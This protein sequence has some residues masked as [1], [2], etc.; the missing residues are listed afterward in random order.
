MVPATASSLIFSYSPEADQVQTPSS[1]VKIC[2]SEMRCDKNA[3][4]HGG[5]FTLS[6]Q[7]RKCMCNLPM[8]TPIPL[9]GYAQAELGGYLG[10]VASGADMSA[11]AKL[12]H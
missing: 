2:S 7:I 10:I 5:K 8:Q 3:A 6:K 1:S 12:I 11:Q 9:A 4:D